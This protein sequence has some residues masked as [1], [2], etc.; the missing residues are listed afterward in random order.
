MRLEDVLL[1]VHNVACLLPH[2]VNYFGMAVACGGGSNA[3]RA[4][5]MLDVDLS[6]KSS[7]KVCGWHL[8]TAGVLVQRHIQH[9]QAMRQTLHTLLG[10]KFA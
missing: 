10:V 8:G 5:T 2:S 4:A 9:T 6:C 7:S 3:C 1:R